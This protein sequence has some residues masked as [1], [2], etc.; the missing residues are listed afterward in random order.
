MARMPETGQAAPPKWTCARCEVTVSWMP[1]MEAP[2]LPP[3]WTVTG[4]EA[5]CLGCRR[6]RA[7]EE[8]TESLPESATLEDKRKKRSHSRIEFEIARSPELPDNRI[9]KSCRTSVIAVRQAR[10]RLGLPAHRPK[11]DLNR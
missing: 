8:G 5:F 6:D 1:E 3:N 9:A 7:G 10:Q 11:P 4:E 2:A